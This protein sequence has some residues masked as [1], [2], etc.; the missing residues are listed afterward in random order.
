M[1]RSLYALF[2]AMCVP[3]LSLL[4]GGC[5]RVPSGVIPPDEMSRL[6]A[7]IHVGES[8]VEYNPST[9]SS[10]SAKENLRQSI[11]RAHGVTEAEVDSSLAWYG[12]NIKLY[13][14]VYEHTLE[15]LEER[16]NSLGNLIASQSSRSFSG[17]SVDIWTGSRHVEISPRSPAQGLRFDLAAD[18]MMQPGDSY[19]WRIKLLNT[20]PNVGL[21]WVTVA[22]YSDG[23]V[24][25][26]YNSSYSRSWHENTFVTDST[27]TVTALRSSA[28]V[29]GPAV[30]FTLDSIMFIRR[31]L[32]PDTYRSHI[33]NKKYKIPGK[34]AQTTD[35]VAA[36]PDSIL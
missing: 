33:H 9:F 17:D 35:S 19:T 22:E 4:L 30:S 25:T 12:H 21:H 29:D 7:D 2:C 15:I 31:R 28:M 1:R 10:D 18:S 34:S 8:Y 27:R 20:E 5:S 24:E 26:N 36:P 6:L 14:D 23:L 3:G 13:N 16:R 11:F 32:Q